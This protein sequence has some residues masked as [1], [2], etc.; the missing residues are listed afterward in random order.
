M[1][2][3]PLGPRVKRSNVLPQARPSFHK[4]GSRVWVGGQRRQLRELTSRWKAGPHPLSRADG[5]VILMRQVRKDRTSEEPNP[6][7]E[8]HQEMW[9]P[10]LT[11]TLG[12]VPSVPTPW[13]NKDPQKLTLLL[14]NSGGQGGLEPWSDTRGQKYIGIF[15][16]M[17]NAWSRFTSPGMSRVC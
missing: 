5:K 13:P 17:I 12:V 2:F 4:A 10:H 3:L 7:G 16:Q 6:A 9:Y 8:H 15:Q 1:I 11:I 14:L